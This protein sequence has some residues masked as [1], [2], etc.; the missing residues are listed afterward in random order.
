MRAPV[1]RQ[2]PSNVTWTDFASKVTIHPASQSCSMD[3]SDVECSAGTICTRRAT[4][5]KL[6]RSRSASWVEYMMVP[7]GFAIPM[8]LLDVTPR[9]LIPSAVTVQ[10]C[11]V[12]PE[13]AMA[14]VSGGMIVGDDNRRKTKRCTSIVRYGGHVSGRIIGSW[15]CR[16][17]AASVAVGAV[18]SG[19]GQA[20]TRAAALR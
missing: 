5:G 9:L 4:G 15:G 17:P 8:G 6:G 19:C 20:S 10:K 12:L 11:A 14:S 13:S 3:R 1:N 7:L 2:V 16:L 18:G